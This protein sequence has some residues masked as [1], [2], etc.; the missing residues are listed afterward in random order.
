MDH[1]YKKY[2]LSTRNKIDAENDSTI[3]SKKGICCHVSSCFEI[4]KRK[5]IQNKFEFESIVI[6]SK[7]AIEVLSNLEI[8]NKANALLRAAKLVE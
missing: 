7:N 6:T 1:S 3:L 8:K 5:N 2:I 4:S